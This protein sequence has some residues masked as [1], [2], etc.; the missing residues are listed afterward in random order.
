MQLAVKIYSLW[1]VFVADEDVNVG[2]GSVGVTDFIHEF[3]QV[4]KESGVQWPKLTLLP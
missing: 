3:T 1:T 4:S 2:S